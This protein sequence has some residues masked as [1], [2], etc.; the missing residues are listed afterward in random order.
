M[1][2]GRDYWGNDD[3][4]FCQ[5]CWRR[6]SRRWVLRD[7]W[8]GLA[9]YRYPPCCVI[10][11]AADSWRGLPSAVLRGSRGDGREFVPCRLHCRWWDRPSRNA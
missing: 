10:H 1:R 6:K 5:P 2:S 4:A 8:Y 9:R 11:Y 3:Y 7:L